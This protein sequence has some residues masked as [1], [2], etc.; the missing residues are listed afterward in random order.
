MNKR[1]T[2]SDSEAATILKCLLSA[3]GHVHSKNYVHR[4][5]K[6]DN[7]LINDP[8]DLS[9]IKLADFGLSASFRINIVYSLNERMGTLI[10]MAPEQTKNHSYGKVIFNLILQ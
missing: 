3:V 9:T 2:F 8:E 10:Y 4:D 6:P 5:L 7:I 1:K